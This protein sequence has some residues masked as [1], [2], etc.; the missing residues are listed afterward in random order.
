MENSCRWGRLRATAPWLSIVGV[1]GNVLSQGPDG[2]FHAE[3]YVPYQQFPWVLSPEHLLVR[4]SAT[5]LPGTMA[6]AVV[7]EVHRV[8]KDQP[9]ADIMTMEQ[10]APRADGAA[11]HD[12][13]A[14]GS[15]CRPGACSFGT[16]DLQRAFLYRGAADT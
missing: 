1:V 5:V 2:G 13:G 3:V 7:Q 15:V 9:V 8:D 16:G 10:V 6:H 14:L 12:D 11:T 4:M